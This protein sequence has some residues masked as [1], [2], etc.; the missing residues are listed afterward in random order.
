MS[1]LD[2]LE[3][4]IAELEQREADRAR[5]RQIIDG[6]EWQTLARACDAI[7]RQI[8]AK[9]APMRRMFDTAELGGEQ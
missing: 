3:R 6:A 9:I 7:D 5:L 2:D 4:R 1:R 8:I